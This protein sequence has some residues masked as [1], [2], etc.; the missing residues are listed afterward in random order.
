SK[1]RIV[2]NFLLEHDMVAVNTY[3]Q[4]N[5][6][7]TYTCHYHLKSEPRQIDFVFVSRQIAGVL[8]MEP[9]T[10]KEFEDNA[11]HVFTDGHCQRYSSNTGEC[12][13]MVEACLFLLSTRDSANPGNYHFMENVGTIVFKV[14]SLYVV[15]ILTGKFHAKEHVELMSLMEHLWNRL[16]RVFDVRLLKVKS[17]TGI[18]RNEEADRLAAF[19]GNRDNIA[20]WWR[21]P[22]R[23]ADWGATEFRSR[24]GAATNFEKLA[25]D[26]ATNLTE[27]RSVG[28]VNV[29]PTI[30]EF[31]QAVSSEARVHG[32]APRHGCRDAEAI[33]QAKC[34]LHELQRRR[35]MESEPVSRAL[36]AN[37]VVKQRRRIARL[38]FDV[39]MAEAI[40]AARPAKPFQKTVVPFFWG[41]G[42][43]DMAFSD[44]AKGHWLITYF[45]NLYNNERSLKEDMP[46]WLSQSWH[47]DALSCFRPLDGSLVRRVVYRFKLN[48]TCAEDLVVIE[49][50]ACLDEDTFEVLADVF[51]LRLL[52]HVSEAD[53]T[54]WERV[55][56]QCI[57]K[58]DEPTH[59]SKLRP[60]TIIPVLMKVYLACILELENKHLEN[61]SEVQFAFRPHRQALDVI[62]TLRNLIEKHVEWQDVVPPLI[63][64]DGDLFKA[65]DTVN[66]LLGAQRLVRKGFQN[67]TVAAIFREARKLKSKV[68]AGDVCSKDVGRTQSL[69]QGGPDAPK[70]F[71]LIFDVDLAEFQAECAENKW[72]VKV[73]GAFYGIL[74]LADKFWILGTSLK[75]LQDMVQSFLGRLCRS[76]WSVPLEECSWC[77]TASD[78]IPMALTVNGRDIRRAARSEGFKTLGAIV[79]V[80][81][82]FEKEFDNRISKAWGCYFKCRALLVH[83]SGSLKKKLHLLDMT[84]KLA[85]LWRAGAWIL[86]VH[87]ERAISGVQRKMVRSRKPWTSTCIAVKAWLHEPCN[88]TAWNRGC[89]LGESSSANGLGNWYAKGYRNRI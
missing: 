9:E 1:G 25:G 86:N 26:G 31:T 52:N 67:I 77:T 32:R 61:L 59:P 6:S 84:V 45:H 4:A 8:T 18:A 50:I 29:V 89:K 14:D 78:G 10:T 68:C 71:N 16:S 63:I 46:P 56:V 34:A 47:T 60:I 55:V 2:L 69:C 74:C 54:S 82:S 33:Q 44:E 72:G 65:Y 3:N 80:D 17:H 79:T 35:R 40:Q 57:L 27:V 20:S 15:G 22:Y 37:M 12:S 42:T 24:M 87:Q 73:G 21:R 39:K 76:G 36:V 58:K 5:R 7:D 49:M 85:L 13:A 19:A 62:F 81:N 23:L 53:E 38:Q 30:A 70:V 43:S 28:F 66:H 48:R 64:F 75:M 51:R 83:K 41:P 11:V 88:S